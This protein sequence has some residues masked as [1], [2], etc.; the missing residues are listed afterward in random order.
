MIEDYLKN[1]FRYLGWRLG[2]TMDKA[3]K[4]GDNLFLA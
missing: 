1:E 3:S 2:D 4:E